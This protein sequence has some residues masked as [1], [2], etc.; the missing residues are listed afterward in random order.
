MLKRPGTIFVQCGFCGNTREHIAIVMDEYGVDRVCCRSCYKAWRKHDIVQGNAR[1]F[2]HYLLNNRTG[3]TIQE[4]EREAGVERGQWIHV[5][6]GRPESIGQP[7]TMHVR[8][9]PHTL[10]G[11]W[12][13]VDFVDTDGIA[14]DDILYWRPHV[15]DT[16]NATNA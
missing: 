2:V 11:R 7:V 12:T 8:R 15:A 10:V 3:I 14:V 5:S 6:E 4:A 1:D 16:E 9:G 13:G